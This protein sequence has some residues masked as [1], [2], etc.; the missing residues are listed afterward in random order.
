MCLAN[1]YNYKNYF[2]AMQRKI[3]RLV[4]TDFCCW[5]PIS[6]MAFLN[7]GGVRLP[8]LAYAVSAIILLPI[9]SALNPIIYSN[10]LDKL[11]E[12]IWPP[13]KNVNSTSSTRLST[14]SQF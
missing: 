12:I 14:R 4:M 8:G 1:V 13:K 3:L 10:V 6:I 7:L 11:Y 5:V 9:N 2:T